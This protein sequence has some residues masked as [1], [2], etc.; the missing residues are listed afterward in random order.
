MGNVEVNLN[1]TIAVGEQCLNIAG[2][3]PGVSSVSGAFRLAGGKIEIIGGIAAAVIVALAALSAPD[4]TSKRQGLS[5]AV[6]IL[7]TYFLHGI[8]NAFRGS[9]EMIPFISLVT[10]LPYDLL[11]NR[12]TYLHEDNYRLGFHQ[13]RV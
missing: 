9:I 6:T 3:I 5:R 7:T 10:C 11:K 12:F 1:K 13:V 8:A 2:Y 4:A